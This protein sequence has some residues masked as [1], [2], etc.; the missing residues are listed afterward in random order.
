[1]ETLTATIIESDVSEK[2]TID[3]S[4]YFIPEQLTPLYFT[5]SYRELSHSQR[6]RYN[7]LTGLY[8]N[9]QNVF[10]EKILAKYILSAYLQEPISGELKVRLEQFTSE[11]ERHSA[12]FL[13][14]NHECA[15]E[16]YRSDDHYFIQAS[17]TLSKLIRC[18]CKRPQLFPLFLW[19]ALLQEERSLFYG[20]LFLKSHDLE[21]NFLDLQRE[22]LR[23][24]V[25]HTR[26]DKQLISWA[27]PRAHKTVRKLNAYLLAWMIN[28]FFSTPKRSAVMVIQQ[29]V[30]EHPDLKPKEPRLKQS[31]LGLKYNREF[32]RW[33][34][35]E[36]NVPETFELFRAWPEFKVMTRAMP[37]FIP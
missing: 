35:C 33:L 29:L 14:L 7:Q 21:P 36:E 16:L 30:K 22:H 8:Y 11:E 31:L 28:E 20:R 17:E 34:Y 23:D 18:L 25:D 5:S 32:R 1:M 2:R 12:M 4:R 9:E 37:G 13:R 3:F 19:L 27:W 15:P 26:W 6:L 10:F 24:E